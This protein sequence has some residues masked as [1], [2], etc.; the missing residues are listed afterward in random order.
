VGWFWF[1]LQMATWR[2]ARGRAMPMA[3]ACALA[4][5]LLLLLPCC[6]LLRYA[7][8]AFWGSFSFAFYGSSCP[9]NTISSRPI[10]MW[11]YLS[12]GSRLFLPGHLIGDNESTRC[13]SFV[14]VVLVLLVYISALT[15]YGMFESYEF[16]GLLAK[17]H[18]KN[19][20]ISFS[21]S[22]TRASVCSSLAFTEQWM[23]RVF[24]WLQAKFS[25]RSR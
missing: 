2:A 23:H 10:G 25:T 13:C 1:K 14:C 8:L 3:D 22:Q 5:C 20:L 12:G 17:F 19:R 21:S 16:H 6:R 9:A 15:I 7:L 4:F 11:K 24:A 18:E